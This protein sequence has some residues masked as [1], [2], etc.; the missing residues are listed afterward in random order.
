MIRFQSA[1]V[2]AA[3][4]LMLSITACHNTGQGIKADTRRAI[5]KIDQKLDPDDKKN[6]PQKKDER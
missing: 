2:A 6:A 3:A 1:P 5:E 4:L